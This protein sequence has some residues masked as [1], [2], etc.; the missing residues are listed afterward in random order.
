MAVILRWWFIFTYTWHIFCTLF[1]D[2]TV[3]ST[4]R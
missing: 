2:V 1:V 4:C 3:L